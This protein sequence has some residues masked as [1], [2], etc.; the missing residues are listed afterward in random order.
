MNK[1]NDNAYLNQY[2]DNVIKRGFE[3]YDEWI[4]KKLNSKKIVALSEGAVKLFKK[5]KTIDTLI[6]AL[7][8]LFALDTRIKE[9]Y[10]NIFLCLFSFF[11]WRREIRA[12]K[13]LK[14]EL[15]IPIDETDIRNLIAVEIKKLVETLDDEWNEDGDDDVH[16]GRS[17]G[18]SDDESLAS[19]KQRDEQAPEENSEEIID[20]EKAD[21]KNEEQAKEQTEE[22]S[23]DDF[24]KETIDELKEENDKNQQVTESL[25]EE[26]DLTVKEEK[27]QYEQ[28]NI[29][30]QNEANNGSNELS[31]PS[32]NK[33]TEI[34][35]YN[36]A[37]DSPPL[38]EE[39]SANKSDDTALSFADEVI[40]DNMLKGKEE[41]LN[42]NSIE[43]LEQNKESSLIDD[44]SVQNEEKNENTN[45]DD[46]LYD[47]MLSSGKEDASQSIE[48]TNNEAT[49]KNTE[50][51]TEKTTEKNVES[52]SEFKQ[53]TIHT[54]E[55]KEAIKQEFE[56]LRVPIQVDINQSHDNVIA[57]KIND[58]MSL[59]SKL[60]YVRMQED[61][62][63]EQFTIAM[64]ELG[65][66][67]PVTVLGI[68][69]PSETKSSEAGLNIK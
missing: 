10:N 35:T 32:E 4:D 26:I 41:L 40:L 61:M 25:K 43:D 68:S 19:E 14:S 18:K 11:S 55:N 20:S 57:N 23:E 64:E 63:R 67:D 16:G 48:S 44:I 47:K 3:I 29:D 59:E 58:N 12:L 2:A 42:H 66:N 22:K 13:M 15:N 56:Q 51:P 38:Y 28:E 46:Y 65:Y 45:K 21:E 53:E 36:D 37:V 52:K 60:S 50:N 9:K 49:S 8:Y 54:N 17:N 34:N 30:N 7:A 31:E 62:M 1:K 27:E 6:N 24:Q 5:R 33:L 69:E 39:S